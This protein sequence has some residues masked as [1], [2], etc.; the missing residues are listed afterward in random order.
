MLEIPV[1]QGVRRSG[2]ILRVAV[3]AGKAGMSDA[4]RLGTGVSIKEGAITIQCDRPL[5]VFG[6]FL[7]TPGG[8]QP[9]QI[10]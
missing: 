6:L 3:R 9:E 5:F 8:I 4:V 1:P 2:R 7:A 10:G